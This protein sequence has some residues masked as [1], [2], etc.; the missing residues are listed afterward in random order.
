[1]Q[2][3]LDDSLAL[4]SRTP[5]TLNALLR[6]LPDALAHANEGA[7][8]WD[9][10]A[11]VGHL[12]S[13]ERTDWLPRARIILQFGETRTFDPFDMQGHLREIEG[14]SLNQLLDEFA[15]LRTSNVFELRAWKLQPADLDKRGVHPSQGVVTLSQL[16]ATWAAH[17]LTHLHQ[18][19]R[20]LA[21]QYREAVG[22]WSK[23]LGVLHCNGH[24]TTE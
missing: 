24:S 8:S 18:L 2:P 1:M 6:D 22:S 10:R 15:Q 11:I 20:V 16:L 14:K 23:F 5:A 7:D 9:S 3:T 17:D 21:Y 19:S 4:L 13:G 12:I